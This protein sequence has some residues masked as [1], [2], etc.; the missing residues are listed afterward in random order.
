MK[1]RRNKVKKSANIFLHNRHYEKVFAGG[2]TAD[3]TVK[4]IEDEIPF[5]VPEGWAWCRL[6]KIGTWQSGSTPDRKNINFYENGTI[7]W[8]FTG[9]L[10]DGIITDIP[11]KITELAFNKTSLKLN[12]KGSVCIA[13]YGGTIGKLGILDFPFF[14][15]TI[16][17]IPVIFFVQTSAQIYACILALESSVPVSVKSE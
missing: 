9:D 12:P 10:T 7:P 4:D 15:E 3:G 13:M 5:E 6:G 8:L 14:S 1:F 2:K 16:F 11:N 17:A